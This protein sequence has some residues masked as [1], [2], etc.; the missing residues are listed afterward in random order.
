MQRP[1][2]IA[3]AAGALAAGGTA[4]A[5][6]SDGG[7]VGAM[8]GGDPKEH[9]AEFARDLASKLDGVKPSEVERALG[10]I[11]RERQQEH[12]AQLAKGLT[13]ELDGVSADE[14]EQALEKARSRMEDAFKNGDRPNRAVF[15]ETLASELDKKPEEIREAFK[16][17]RKSAFEAR[18]D[19]AVKEGKISEE[20]ADQIRERLEQGRRGFRGGHHGRFRDRGGFGP[21]GPGRPHG[22]G[23]GGM[24]GPPG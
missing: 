6:A 20:R 13:A 24:G 7:R 5:T 14:V 15:V 10:E 4:I 16:D 8:L 1:I 23:P 12:W 9:R 22:P 3:A 2:A 21:G 17:A 18:L 11:R 19:A